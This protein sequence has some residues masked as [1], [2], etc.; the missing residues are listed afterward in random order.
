MK[1]IWKDGRVEERNVEP[2]YP[3]HVVPVVVRQIDE[4]T[5]E[6]EQHSFSLKGYMRSPYGEARVLV[7][8]EDG[9]PREVALEAVRSLLACS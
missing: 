8:E 9:T 1:F 5:V 6:Y 2:R 3:S 4:R 7:Y